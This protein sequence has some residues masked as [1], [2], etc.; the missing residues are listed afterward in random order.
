MPPLQVTGGTTYVFHL[1]EQTQNSETEKQNLQQSNVG[2]IA[3]LWWHHHDKRQKK[4]L[5]RR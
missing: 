5:L 2:G 3:H 1:F 4:Y